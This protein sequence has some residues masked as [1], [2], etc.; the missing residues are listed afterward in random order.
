MLIIAWPQRSRV[1]RASK[2][3][4]VYPSAPSACFGRNELIEKVVGL[5]ENLEPIALVGPGGVGKT[6]IALTVLHHDRIK[7][8]FGENCRFIHCNQFPP[9]RAH[10]LARLSEAIG[11]RVK[12]PE[13]LT[14][15]RPILSSKEML[16]ILDNAESILDPRGTNAEE[17]YSVMDEL[18]QFK[19]ICLLITSRATT[20][21]S[22]CKRPEIPALSMEAASDIFYSIYSDGGRSST[23]NNLLQRV[24]FHPLSITILAATTSHNAWDCDRLAV[25]WD[26]QQAQI[27]RTDGSENLAAAIELS[28]GSPTFRSLGPDARELLGVTAF[29]PQGI[30]GENID[31]LF[32]TVSNGDSIFDQ[33]CSLSLTY[34]SDNFITMLAPIRDYLSPQD[35]QS[36]PLLCAAKDRY[37][38]RLLAVVNP[39][40]PGF[41]GARWIASED[42]NVE[43]LLDVGMTKQQLVRNILR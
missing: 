13:D 42:M 23:I 29:F 37:C 43:H 5:A 38:S 11:A 9:S 40:E 27:L 16:I 25:E 20:V 34:W 24:D 36:S 2:D 41:R 39:Y 3:R 15:L 12:N 17:I 8:R 4:V 19:T 1:V 10:F 18:C 30:D 22:H 26:I 7:N 31:W 35:P 21:P 33:F 6:S 14:P 32:P 28:L